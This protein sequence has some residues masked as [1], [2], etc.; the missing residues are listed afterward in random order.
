MPLYIP[1]S[2]SWLSIDNT[3]HS[4][5]TS[6]REG[7]SLDASTYV[8]STSS[9][10]LVSERSFPPLLTIWDMRDFFCTERTK[11]V[12]RVKGEIALPLFCSHAWEE[13]V[14]SLFWLRSST[15]AIVATQQHQH[16]DE[17]WHQLNACYNNH[18][19]N[20]VS[21]AN[22]ATQRQSQQQ[23]QSDALASI[24]CQV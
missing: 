12:H 8:L 19:N 7:D 3:Y 9:L 2:Y 10:F 24:G 4:S 5:R 15:K 16:S 20:K 1:W 18:N 22:V 23:H 6:S 14:T 17:P 11:W 13:G 21:V